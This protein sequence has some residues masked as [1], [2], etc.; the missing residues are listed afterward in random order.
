MSLHGFEL[1]EPE[2]RPVTNGKRRPHLCF[3]GQAERVGWT[4]RLVLAI[5]PV[6]SHMKRFRHIHMFDARD[7]RL[8]PMVSAFPPHF[9]LN[10]RIP[11]AP[12][13]PMSRRHEWR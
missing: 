12:F 13:T 11:I 6:L 1:A 9:F 5:A 2:V 4:D 7:W 8:K 10:E 3:E